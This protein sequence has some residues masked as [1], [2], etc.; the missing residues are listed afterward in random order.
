MTDARYTP[1]HANHKAAI[2]PVNT[3]DDRAAHDL[4]DEHGIVG[5]KRGVVAGNPTAQ[6]LANAR[7]IVGRV[8]NHTP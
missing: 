4:A 7:G 3:H 5:N 6:D 1:H 2:P 8:R